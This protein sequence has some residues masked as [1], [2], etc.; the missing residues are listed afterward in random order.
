MKYLFFDV[1][2]SN[3]FAAYDEANKEEVKTRFSRPFEGKMITY[4]ELMNLKKE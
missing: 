3:F 1:E 4:E 2:C